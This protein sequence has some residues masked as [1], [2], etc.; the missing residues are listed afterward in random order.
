[1]PKYIIHL[2]VTG[3]T[4]RSHHAAAN[5]RRICDAY[6]GGSYELVLIDVLAQPDLA[7]A[8]RILAT[9]TTVR[10]A[11]LPAYRVIGDMS[12]SS[13]VMMAL[14][15]DVKDLGSGKEIS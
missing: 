5:L 7:E 10:V 11:P 15:L 13:K 1:M 2:Y 6:V 12:D 8:A 14:G 3:Q 4:A 9:P